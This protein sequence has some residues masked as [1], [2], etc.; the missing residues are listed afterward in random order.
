MFRFR[1]LLSSCYCKTPRKHHGSTSA[2]FR[3]VPGFTAY[4]NIKS[5]GSPNSSGS[6]NHEPRSRQYLPHYLLPTKLRS[7]TFN[8]SS[9][10]RGIEAQQS[11]RRRRRLRWRYGGERCVWRPRRV[12][13]RGGGTLLSLSDRRVPTKM[14]RC[15]FLLLA[16]L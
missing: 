4:N 6:I 7:R 11:G 1:L 10:R 12:K 16:L 3:N 13:L 8:S 15:R 2:I 5:E 14:R 9:S